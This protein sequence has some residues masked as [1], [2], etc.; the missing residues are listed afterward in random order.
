MIAKIF[1]LCLLGAPAWAAPEKLLIEHQ[2]VHNAEDG[3]DLPVGY[4]FR[5]GDTVYFNFRITGYAKK[6]ENDDTRVRLSWRVLVEDAKGVPLVDASA[7]K[8]DTLISAEDKDWTPV[9]RRSFV[10]TSFT[11]S[12]EY[13]VLLH[14]KDEINGN[15]ASS[16]TPFRV[17]GHEIAP[18][19]ALA[20]QNFRFLRS[21]EDTE[22]LKVAAYR[23]GDTLWVRFDITGYKLGERN[24]FSVDYGVRILRPDGSLAY[25]QPD[26]AKA[27]DAPFYPQ[28]YVPGIFSLNIPRDLK[29]G[30][31]TLTVDAADRTGAQS[32]EVS[33]KFSVE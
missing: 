23:P 32:C 16:E 3:A 22:P 12:G 20:V 24:R 29:T 30:E 31:Y 27:S 25:T 6:E 18:G 21:E 11:P 17:A 33:A 8:E 5:P 9:G 28:L 15:E 4:R 7:G 13:R 14:V 2:S 26:A 10:L 1:V 19:A